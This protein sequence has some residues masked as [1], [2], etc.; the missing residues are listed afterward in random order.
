MQPLP[1]T[2]LTQ[3]QVD[4]RVRAGHT[5]RSDSGSSRSVWSIVRVNLFTLFNLIIALGTVVLIAIGR[6]QDAIFSLAALSNVIIGVVQEY[7]AKRKLDKLALIHATASRVMR[8]GEVHEISP[9][10]IVVDDLVV[11][12]RGNQVVADG[13]VVESDGLDVDEALLTGESE[14]V[15]KRPGDEVL[16]GS[17]VVTGSG[18]YRVTRVG[19]EAYASKL[20]AEAKRFSMVNSELR[21][22]LNRVVRWV[23]FALI[24][25]VLVAVNGQMQAVGGW[26]H[27]AASGEWQDAM[28][29]A[30]A[31]V[32][33]S[34]PQG[35]ILMTSIAFAVAA[36][37]LSRHNVLTQ[38]LAA[39]EGLARV[40]LICLDKTGT[41]TEGTI[42][43]DEVHWMADEVA[44]PVAVPQATA[45]RVAVAAR[46]AVPSRGAVPADDAMPAG[47][48]AT[49]VAV[50]SRGA[51]DAA[52]RVLAWFG[53]DPNANATAAALGERFTEL[54]T[55]E[56][57]AQI[58]FTSAQR[59]SSVTFADGDCAGV[60]VL[61][62]PET[63]LA[64]PGGAHPAAAS[65]AHP[66]AKL[67]ADAAD[68]GLRALILTRQSASSPAAADQDPPSVTACPSG[69]ASPSVAASPSLAAH[70]PPAPTETPAAEASWGVPVAVLTF[71]ERVRSDAAE[72]LAYFRD[73]DV[74]V[75]ILSGDNP[76]TVA[77]VARAVGLEMR[78]EAFDAREL[79]TE[80]SALADVLE[81]HT[82]FG[83]VSPDQKK[84]IVEA[85]Q[86]A[87]HTVAMT[88]DG[89]NDALALK[90]ADLGVAMGSGAD[91]TKAVARIVL[92][93]SKFSH[94]PHVVAEGRQVI[95]NIERVSR[96]FLTKTVYAFTLAV[97]FGL[98]MWQFPLLPRQFGITD[99]LTI[100]IPAFFLALLPNTR[101]YI[102]GFLERALRF[103]VPVGLLIAVVV[104]TVTAL[105]RFGMSA[106][107]PQ[108][109]G[110][111]VIALTVAGLWVLVIQSRPLTPFRVVL[112]VSMI[113]TLVGFFSIPP[114]LDFLSFAVPHP[115]LLIVAIAVGAAAA[116]VIEAVHRLVP[117][118]K[119]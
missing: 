44:A 67:A 24:P 87:G 9:A 23:S 27:A 100:G 65:A 94:L 59:M 112:V 25:L 17:A 118:T 101:R 34:I 30:I 41:L 48:D 7:S 26:A 35:L 8:D 28:V 80:P 73:Q 42:E 1:S 16:S 46:G 19:A 97:I 77:A 103:C 58:P 82:V 113:V 32:S 55:E 114:V 57:S 109:Q 6:W 96:I 104:V 64:E 39:V 115:Q 116:V 106:P 79:P 119:A 53:A 52:S 29:R 71:R 74:Q 45:A 43:F 89:V 47:H 92:L 33:A 63:V 84:G 85:L 66:V 72:T 102:P 3:Q 18:C 20:T 22:S 69:G 56:A 10:D 107:E 31:S 78:G 86:S 60:W 91:A 2:G 21:N 50:P 40:D 108:V 110:A 98:L 14:P 11:I 90:T 49:R 70:I 61:G 37:K 83:R 95:A 111:V 105:A 15:V 62:A 5:N 4:D 51:G 76:R 99:G 36:V 81:A 93:D 13:E 75:R 68:Q 54:P 38:E 12:Q 88:G 117:A